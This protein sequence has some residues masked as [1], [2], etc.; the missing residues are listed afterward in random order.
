MGTSPPAAATG[1]PLVERRLLVE[2]CKVVSDSSSWT[3]TV[4]FRRVV[5]V[6]LAAVQGTLRDATWGLAGDS[7]EDA[8]GP[9]T[10]Y[11]SDISRIGLL[12]SVSSLN[13]IAPGH[14]HV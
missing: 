9:A 3:I 2:G 8:E 10:L 12:G 11:C 1:S 7:V 5:A 6:P 13:K 14:C 4:A